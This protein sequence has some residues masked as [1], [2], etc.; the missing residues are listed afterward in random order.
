MISP[1][2]TGVN[3]TMNIVG[4]GLY[5]RGVLIPKL[6]GLYGMSLPLVF[7]AVFEGG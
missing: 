3:W 5:Y 7:Q 1:N 6:H 2:S 4:E